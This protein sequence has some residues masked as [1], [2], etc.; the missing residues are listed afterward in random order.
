MHPMLNIAIQA[1][2]QASKVI[3]RFEDQM[4][5]V[6]ISEKNEND[7]VTQVDHLSE[8]VIIEQIRKSYPAHTILAEES[9]MH[10]QEAQNSEY[11]WIIDPLDGTKNFV[12]GFPQY[13]ISIALMHK[14]ALMLAVVYDPIRQDLFTATKGQGAYLNSRRIRVSQTKKLEDAL[15][16]TGFPF[17]DKQHIKPY[18]NTFQNIFPRVSGIRRAGA[19][20]LDLAYVAAGKLDGFW[21]ASLKPWDMAAGVLLIKEAGGI[22]SDFHNEGNFIDSGNIIAGNPRI[23]KEL[24]GLVQQSLQE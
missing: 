18:L 11:C 17:R 10:K 3:L 1:A 6:S 22:V 23:H 21:E 9:G 19:A 20:A 4:D 15:L 24:T 7:L 14:N 2:R 8:E 5:K 12:H 16:G 13:A